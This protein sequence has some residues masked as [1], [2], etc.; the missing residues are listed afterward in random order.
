MP[1]HNRTS[2]PWGKFLAFCNAK[3]EAV[4]CSEDLLFPTHFVCAVALQ[5]YH[6]DFNS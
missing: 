2:A 5:V 1:A 6:Y 3:G 4:K